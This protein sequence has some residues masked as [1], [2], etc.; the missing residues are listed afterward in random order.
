MDRETIIIAEIGENHVGDWDLAREMIDEAADAGADIVKFQSYFGEMVANEDPE[1]EWFSEVEVPDEVHFGLK[2]YAENQGVEF[3]SSP[4]NLERTRFLVEDLGLS[5][6]KI[7][8]PVM[9]RT[10]MLE[11]L[12][13]QVDTVYISTGLSTLDEVREALSYLTDVQDIC[14][15][16][17]TSEYP[18][19]PSHAN[20]SVLETYRDTFPDHRVGFSDHT[21]GTLAAA[22]SVALGATVV[23]KHF[24][25]DKS[26]EGTDHVLSVTPPELR[27]MTGRIERVETLLGTADKRPTEE[28][29]EIIEFARNRF[30]ELP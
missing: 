19:A 9:L 10:D 27:E 6:I 8:S 11:Y 16:Q 22:M 14:I 28:E 24:T 3:L 1:K 21:L 29:S 17:C 2:E 26:L 18:C 23:E 13:G 30:A 4:F 15:M 7:A 5:T 12:N 25:L 20:L